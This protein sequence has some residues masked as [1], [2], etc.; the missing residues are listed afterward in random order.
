MIT[1]FD[2]YHQNIFKVFKKFV[3]GQLPKKINQQ[4][5]FTEK[6]FL[7]IMIYAV[8]YF[9]LRLKKGTTPVLKHLEE[10]LKLKMKFGIIVKATFRAAYV[11]SNK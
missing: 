8:C 11:L 9:Q 1:C 2:A 3:I 4:N 10:K 6:Y 7:Q 5:L